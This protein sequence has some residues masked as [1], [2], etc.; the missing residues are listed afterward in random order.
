[1]FQIKTSLVFAAALL[2]VWIGPTFESGG[3]NPSPT[4]ARPPAPVLVSPANGAAL[5][6][7]ITLD[8]NPVSA[9]GGPIG[10][11]TWQVGTSS[12]FTTVI[13]SGFTNMDSDPSIPT[14]TADKV[15]GLPNGTYFWRVKCSQLGPNGGVDSRWSTV[16]SFTVTGLG[17]A[18]A[19]PSFITPAN[20]AQF[21][22]TE[23]FNIQWSP[24]VNAQSYILEADDEPTFSY[25]LTLQLEPI[26]FG[27]QSGA[28]WGNPLTI[29]YRVR[30]VSV[31]GVRSLPSATRT[32]QITNAAPIPAGVSP[33]TP[34]SG[35]TVR[36][37]F[38]VDWSDTPNPQVPGYD[39]E[40]NTSPNFPLAGMVLL[41]SPSRSDYMI[42]RDLL[43]PGNYFW[44][45]RAL[46][47]DVAGL[48][49]AGRAIT[50]TAPIAPPNVNLF[51]ILA[52]P[53][54]AYGGNTAHARVMLD[55]PAPAGGAVVSISTDIPQVNMPATRVTVPAGKT[56]ATI[57]NIATDPVPNG[58][59]SVGI[60]GDLFAGF[61]NGR[62][63]NSFGV[64]PILYGTSLNK[65]SVVGGTSVN[66]TVT[67]QSAAPAGGITVRLVSSDPNIVRPPA[68]VFIPAGATDIDFAV[69]TSAVSVPMRVIIETGTDV[70][71]YPAPQT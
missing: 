65:E 42:T 25:P 20:N 63:Q 15:S 21:H 22:V 24:V 4:P 8:W 70:D 26:S 5:A 7:P 59:V 9:P 51:A 62:G 37:P 6:Q 71:G 68:T 41:V 38:F 16:R 53:V 29:F 11:Y 3:Q 10:S 55:N 34:A 35:A 49:S 54:N 60:I 19:T 58:G 61:A 36:L 17:P 50:M 56:D 18:P 57:A 47:G 46:H 23:S 33:V 1:M 40:F 66:A 67:L 32:V 52:E 27:T 14:R 39:L 30:A 12:T 64:L 28:I 44:R 48:W 13:A 2:L 43:A 45:V 31:D 69:P